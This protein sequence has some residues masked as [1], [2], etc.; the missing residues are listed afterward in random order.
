MVA[1]AVVMVMSGRVC[2]ICHPALV[3]ISTCGQGGCATSIGNR[4]GSVELSILNVEKIVS[5]PVV[6]GDALRLFW[7]GGDVPA[8]STRL[9]AP[10]GVR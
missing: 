9:P 10:G 5:V 3:M 8:S 7:V 6:G 4:G 1:V 2:D